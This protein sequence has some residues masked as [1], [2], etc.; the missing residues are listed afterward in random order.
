MSP[1][2]RDTIWWGKNLKGGTM[3]KSFASAIVLA[4]LVTPA[5][6]GEYWVVHAPSTTQKCSIVEKTP[7]PSETKPAGAIASPFKTRAEAEG[8]VQ[9]QRICGGGHDS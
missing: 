6:A 8:F 3:L 1:K 5:L 9:Q 4:A 2:V 7:Q